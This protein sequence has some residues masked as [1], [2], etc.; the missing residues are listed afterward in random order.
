MGNIMIC[1]VS[2]S[3]EQGPSRDPESVGDL[4]ARDHASSG[5]VR[6]ILKQPV[7]HSAFVTN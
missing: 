5:N 7:D 3:K 6:S 1:C 2:E 4:V